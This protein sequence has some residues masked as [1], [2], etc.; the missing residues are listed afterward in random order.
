MDGDGRLN[1]VGELPSLAAARVIT[2]NA[3]ALPCSARNAVAGST[4]LK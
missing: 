4:P 1:R 2:D 3:Q